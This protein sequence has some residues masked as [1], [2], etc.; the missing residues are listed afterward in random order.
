MNIKIKLMPLIRKTKGR[1]WFLPFII[2]GGNKESFL[3][4]LPFINIQFNKNGLT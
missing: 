4:M 1:N 2:F 3:I